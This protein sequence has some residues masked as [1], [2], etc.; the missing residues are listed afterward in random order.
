MY[1]NIILY[2]FFKDRLFF[3][4]NLQEVCN[5]STICSADPELKIIG[6][7]IKAVKIGKRVHD[8]VKAIQERKHRRH[9]I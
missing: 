1:V 4:L 7:L 8:T 6:T 2:F 5:K 9:S 3:V